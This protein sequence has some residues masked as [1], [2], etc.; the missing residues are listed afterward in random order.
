MSIE[1]DLRAVA[2]ALA[3]DVSVISVE[4][5]ER[6]RAGA[7][8]YYR[9][10]DPMLLE[11]ELPSITGALTSIIHGLRHARHLPEGAPEGAL[12]EA[13]V[14]AQAGVELTDLLLTRRI[15]QVVLRVG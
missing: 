9:R 15:G 1:Q 3:G 8:N 6:S 14:A 7:P 5:Q 4:I 10:N 2:D 12:E 11:A 13:R